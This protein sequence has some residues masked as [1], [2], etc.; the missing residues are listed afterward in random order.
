MK[1][2]LDAGVSVEYKSGGVFSPLTTAIREGRKEIAQFLLD[3]AGANVNA[4]GEHLLII[5]AI[6]R[7]QCDSE[8]LEMLLARGADINQ[9]YQG[10]NAVLQVVENGDAPILR[11]LVEREVLLILRPP[12][13]QEDQW[14]IS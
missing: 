4:P 14:W 10:W 8:I 9:M 3:E 12:T 5:K 11:L 7:Y 1:L 6:R 2:L 13:S